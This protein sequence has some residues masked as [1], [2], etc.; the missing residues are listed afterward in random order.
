MDKFNVNNDE[1]F[2]TMKMLEFEKNRIKLEVGNRKDV[3]LEDSF[4]ASSVWESVSLMAQFLKNMP[5]TPVKQPT[6]SEGD[7]ASNRAFE[8]YARRLINEHEA[9]FKQ[10]IYK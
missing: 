8:K 5:E 6:S 1:I 10:V 7:K 9:L 3:S 4:D 2:T